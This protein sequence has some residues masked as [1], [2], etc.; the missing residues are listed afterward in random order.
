MVYKD[1]II[2]NVKHDVLPIKHH[3]CKLTYDPFT[4]DYDCGYQTNLTCDECKYGVGKKDPQ[5][6][7]N[8]YETN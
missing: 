3:K 2:L 4:G 8:K 7:V 6:K 5:A 1:F